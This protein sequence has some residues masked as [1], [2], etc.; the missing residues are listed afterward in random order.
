MKY[1][2]TSEMIGTFAFPPVRFPIH[3]TKMGQRVVVYGARDSNKTMIPDGSCG[4]VNAVIEDG[5][6]TSLMC[7][8]AVQEYPSMETK[9]RLT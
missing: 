4:V 5:P 9:H 2:S 8:V 1:Y 7:T 6:R 3:P